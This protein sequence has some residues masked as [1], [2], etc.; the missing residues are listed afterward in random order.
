MRN[1]GHFHI[2]GRAREL[3]I[4][5]GETIYPAEI[6]GFLVGHPKLAEAAV[7]GLPD[8]KL[9]EIVAAW[10]RL[11]P[12]EVMTQ[13]ELQDYCQGKIAHFKIP[14]HVRFVDAFP[15]T[16][17]GKLQKFRIREAEI[18]ARGLG[19]QNHDHGL[20][21]EERTQSRVTDQHRIPG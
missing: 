2:R 10:V 7:V 16:V 8:L 6:E 19:R 18:E 11:R 17:T 9:G 3:I 14:Q 13:Q 20:E 15:M 5:S 12:G 21:H 4:R 1:D